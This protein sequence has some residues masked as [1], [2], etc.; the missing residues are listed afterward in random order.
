M[1][2]L[3]P[4]LQGREGLYQRED[5]EFEKHWKIQF[6]DIRTESE[7]VSTELKALN[8]SISCT[9]I[10]VDYGMTDGYVQGMAAMA[11]L[12]TVDEIRR[13]ALLLAQ[14]Q[15]K[16]LTQTQSTNSIASRL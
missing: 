6:A 3:I 4:C 11:K 2:A 13:P 16:W 5:N 10:D 15:L 14:N 8:G 9:L 1:F 7:A 12:K